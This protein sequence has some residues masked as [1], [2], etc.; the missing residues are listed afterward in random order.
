MRSHE[1]LMVVPYSERQSKKTLIFVVV[2]LSLVAAFYLGYSSG[3]FDFE[4]EQARL[5]TENKVLLERVSVISVISGRLDVAR[6]KLAN[7]ERG[8]AIDSRAEQDVKKVIIVLKEDNRRLHEELSF[9]KKIMS[10]GVKGTNLSVDRIA[11]S[12]T[13][14]QNKFHYQ[15][16]LTKVGNN[17]KFVK[18]DISIGVSGTLGGSEQAGLIKDG[19]WVKVEA[20]NTSFSSSGRF[21]FRYF[22]ELEGDIELPSDF[23]PTKVQV[24]ATAVISKKKQAIDRSF[25][26]ELEK[27]SF[28]VE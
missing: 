26:W 12:A 13:K 18:G 10:P 6:Q 5:Y 21:K 15:L 11:L 7:Y 25:D 16:V 17:K 20:N 8:K 3:Q 19:V 9:Y 1:R 14:D 23:V 2:V 4:E 27:G 28:H 24:T 22:Q